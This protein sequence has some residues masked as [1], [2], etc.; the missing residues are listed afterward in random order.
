M[1]TISSCTV[2]YIFE[3]YKCII[4]VLWLNWWVLYL[5]LT[6][7]T[8]WEFYW[9]IDCSSTKR[10]LVIASDQAFAS[11]PSDCLW[12]ASSQAIACSNSWPA[13]MFPR[14]RFTPFFYIYPLSPF[15]KLSL[16]LY[17]CLSSSL[18]YIYT[19]GY[20]YIYLYIYIHPH[21]HTLCL[22]LSV[23]SG[24]AK[25]RERRIEGAEAR[26]KEEEEEEERIYTYTLSLY[27]VSLSL[28]LIRWVLKLTQYPYICVVHV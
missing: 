7:V 16:S 8:F 11:H 19:H 4:L 28:S 20:I 18:I 12:T 10:L 21:G 24:K 27:A 13:R 2:P 25:R 26:D 22:P 9:P 14:L 6:L 5:C 15:R 17:L 1:P 3:W 23:Y